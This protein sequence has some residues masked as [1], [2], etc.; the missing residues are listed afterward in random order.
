MRH[1]LLSYDFSYFYHIWVN[2]ST[3]CRGVEPNPLTMSGQL[4]AGLANR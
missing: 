2:K 4:T 1:R 3:P